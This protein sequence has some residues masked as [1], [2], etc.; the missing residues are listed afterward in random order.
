MALPILPIQ[1]LWINLVSVAV[2]GLVLALEPR[3]PDLM[4]RR[5][6]EPGTPILTRDAG[7]ACGPGR[8][9]PSWRAP[10]GCIE[11]QL[12]EGASVAQARTVAVTAVILIEIFYLLNCRSLDELLLRI[13]LFSNRWVLA[14]IPALLLLQIAF[15]Y[16]PVM[17]RLFQSAPIGLREWGLTTGAGLATFILIEAEKALRRR[18]R[19]VRL[20]SQAVDSQLGGNAGG[21][22]AEVVAMTGSADEEPRPRALPRWGAGVEGK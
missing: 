22:L 3:E 18:R 1:I 12:Y 4:R 10:S 7:A 6:R 15:V 17:N 16:L 11:L 20:R 21:R 2:L 8:R 5:P 13:G 19:K 9:R 14:G